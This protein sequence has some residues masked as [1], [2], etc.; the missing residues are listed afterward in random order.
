MSG[1]TIDGLNSGIDTA[2]IVE[3]LLEIQETQIARITLQKDEAL[4]KQTAY[5]T[6]EAQLV[7]FRSAASTLGRSQNNVF[8]SRSVS[9]S[10]E[11]ALVA[12][13]SSQAA[14]GLY[15]VTVDQ[16]ASA[17]QV[18]SQGFADADSQITQG[19]F[20]IRQ[21]SSTAFDITI[22]D[23]NDTLQGLA[24]AINLT[25]SGITASIVNDG[26]TTG[27]RLL[28]ASNETGADNDISV[29][30]S[31]AADSGGAV[32]PSFDFDNPVQAAQ[33]SI[34]KLGSG[35]GALAVENSGNTV[36]GLIAGVTLDLAQADP[37]R[38]ISIR[39]EQ[40]TDSAVNAVQ[41]FVDSF[42]SVIDY[43]DGVTAFDPETENGGVL[44]GE[45]GISTI[46]SQI[47][48]ALLEV[49]PNASLDANRLSNIGI[50]F[51]DAGKLVLNST[52]LQS[53]VSG[54]VDG[55]DSSDLRRMFA[56]DGASTNPNIE[57][58]LGSTRTEATDGPIEIDI[59]RAPERASVTG[60]NTVAASTVIDSSNDE[61]VITIDNEELT[62]TLSEGTYTSAELADEL[63]SVINNHPDARGR[64]VNVGVVD[65]G[66]GA[67][68]LTVTSE[69]YGDGSQVTVGSGT[70]LTALGFDGSENDQGVDVAGNFIVNGVIE[71]ATGSGRILSGDR[72]NSTTA[73]LQVRV[74]LDSAQVASG[75]DGELTVS[76]GFGSRLDRLIGDLT[77]SETGLLKS[78]DDQF[79]EEAESVQ[80]T[81]D[82]QSEIFDEQEQELLAQF[83]ALESAIGELNTTS[84][85]LTQQFASLSSNN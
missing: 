8:E 14:R 22:D 43:I 35:A 3:G 15:T 36:E 45:R 28:L 61:L 65:D 21:G 71:E 16:L 10:D 49:V 48:N 20:S 57:F 85:F 84:S 42:N 44:L 24:D 56:L 72:E 46:Q 69:I 77:D 67:D 18:A 51:T 68:K 38:P 25:D 29:T 27:T 63:E 83:V 50:S 4:S 37:D 31:L 41:N 9:V 30:N 7:S 13:A 82:R 80:L 62:V 19:T 58:L 55:V 40:N 23:S 70:A 74:T 60:A 39:V 17:H 11:D 81:I 75:A 1:I 34:V 2:S 26:S 52:E 78:I 32:K 59:T 76:R 64:S 66:F 12:T 73:D 53:V 54:E 5:R 6:L 79:A 47:Q 33:N